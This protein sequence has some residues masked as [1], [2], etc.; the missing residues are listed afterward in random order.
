MHTLNVP[1]EPEGPVVN[2]LV[3]LNAADV[4]ILRMAGRPVPQPL[5]LRALI[6][7]GAEVSCVDA[8]AIAPLVLLGVTPVR[9]VIA[10]LPVAG[11]LLP[12][13]EYTV[14]LSIVHPSGKSRANLVLP[15]QSIVELSLGQLGYQVLIGRDVLD[16]CL[17]IYNG[18]A[19]HL[20]LV[21]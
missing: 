13:A 12:A 7:T 4:R 17:H 8:Q 18:P 11:G 2:V 16:R 5:S 3:G 6:D 9:Y 14:S 1:I 19:Q 15:S 10:N 20:T 21:Y